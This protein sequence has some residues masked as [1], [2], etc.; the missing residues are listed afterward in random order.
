MPGEVRARVAWKRVKK[1]MGMRCSFPRDAERGTVLARPP[2]RVVPRQGLPRVVP[3]QGL[4]RVVPRQGL[5]R[6][7]PRQGLPRVVPR[8]GLPRVVPR[9]GLPRVVPRQ[10]LPRVVHGTP[11]QVLVSGS[12]VGP[13]L[14]LG[15]TVSPSS[16][17]EL[18]AGRRPGRKR[19][20]PVRDTA[21]RG[22]AQTRPSVSRAPRPHAGDPEAL[23]VLLPS[24][25]AGT[26]SQAL[27]SR[28]VRVRVRRLLPPQGMSWR[29]GLDARW[30]A[31]GRIAT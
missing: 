23:P 3:R 8:Q 29:F 4:P 11:P 17:V 28:P 10:G 14:T 6:V 7:V 2:P 31:I 9:Q 20:R 5:P 25:A 27:S 15:R 22:S 13:E 21:A 1:E 12:A 19:S 18:R 16:A 30:G 24:W 26:P